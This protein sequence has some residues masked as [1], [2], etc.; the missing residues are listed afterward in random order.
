MRIM[1]PC[2]ALSSM[3]REQWNAV[4]WAPWRDSM[5]V[6]ARFRSRDHTMEHDDV[7]KCKHFPRYT[8]ALWGVSTGY[9]WIPFTK[10]S[11]ADL[12][13]F[14]DRRLNKRLSKQ[15]R[16]GWFETPLLSLWRYYNENWP[17]ASC[18]QCYNRERSGILKHWYMNNSWE[19]LL[20][21]Q[22]S[23]NDVELLLLHIFCTP[24]LIIN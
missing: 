6:W 19:S 8:G 24:K 12:W 17:M 23:I 3:G 5:S 18:V 7:I 1:F 15:T 22:P 14:F 10:A 2:S 4:H 11:D 13:C 9:L 20:C 21:D 16:R